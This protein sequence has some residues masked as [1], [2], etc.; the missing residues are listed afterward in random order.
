VIETVE[1]AVM[2]VEGNVAGLCGSWALGTQEEA[3]VVVGLIVELFVD[4]VEAASDRWW[5]QW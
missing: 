1:S 4:L 5:A 2:W 3:G